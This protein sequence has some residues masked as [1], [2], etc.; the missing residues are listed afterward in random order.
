MKRTTQ[1]R[2]LLRR[3]ETLVAPLA[4]C[5]YTAKIVEA[6][7]FPAVYLSG[8]GTAGTLFGVPDAGL[9]T[10]EERGRQQV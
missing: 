6:A 1:L 5:A 10:S 9:V 3:G 7:G 2:D 8:G 4:D